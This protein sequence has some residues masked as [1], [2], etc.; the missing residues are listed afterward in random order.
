M[1]PKYAYTLPLSK[2]VFLQ[3]IQ[4]VKKLTKLKKSVKYMLTKPT[5]KEIL[6]KD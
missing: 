3:Y 1:M 4:A 2:V 5:N 6:W